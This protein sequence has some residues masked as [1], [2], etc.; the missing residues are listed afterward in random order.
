M[1]GSGDPDL[2]KAFRDLAAAHPGRR[3]RQRS[4]STTC[5]R[6]RIEAGADFFLMPSRFEPCGLNQLISMRYGTPPIVRRTGGLADTV[7]DA[8]PDAIARGEATGIVFD[9]DAPDALAAAIDRA[10]ALFRDAD[11]LPRRPAGRA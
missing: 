3:S 4:S 6:T 1:L 7:T 9:E 8:T 11:G 10:V 2:E 5:S